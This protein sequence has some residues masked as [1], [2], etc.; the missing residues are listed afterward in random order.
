MQQSTNMLCDRFVVG[1]VQ[2]GAP[3]DVDVASGVVLHNVAPAPIVATRARRIVPPPRAAHPILV[4]AARVSRISLIVVVR[5]IV[6]RRAVIIANDG[7]FDRRV[8]TVIRR[9]PQKK[10]SHTWCVDIIIVEGVSVW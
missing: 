6:V 3:T 8:A 2:L 5:R 1:E 4:R 10:P 7:R 9:T